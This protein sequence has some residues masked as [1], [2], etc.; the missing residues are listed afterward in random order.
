MKHSVFNSHKHLFKYSKKKKIKN[1]MKDIY[2]T[3]THRNFMMKKKNIISSHC[4]KFDFTNWIFTEERYSAWHIAFCE[5][6][7]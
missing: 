3:W 2:S 4:V 5:M 7:V 6:C 1:N